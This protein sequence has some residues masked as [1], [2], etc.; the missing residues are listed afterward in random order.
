MDIQLNFGEFKVR[1]SAQISAFN[2]GHFIEFNIKDGRTERGPKMYKTWSFFKLS[3][4][5]TAHSLNTIEQGILNLA[6]GWGE[7]VK[8]GW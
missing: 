6:D 5:L 1:L 4:P 2:F 3:P 8:D 7:R